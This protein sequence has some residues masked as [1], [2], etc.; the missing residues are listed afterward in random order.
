VT[1][2]ACRSCGQS[3][4]AAILSLGRTPLANALPTAEELELPEATYPLDLAFCTGC[5]LVQI[6]ETVPPEKLFRNYL[7]F[8]SF[9]DTLL[10][11]ARAIA[12]RLIESR[13]LDGKSL[14]VEAASNDGYLLQYY[15]HQGV[16]VL[17]IEPALNVARVAETERGIPTLREFF[18]QELARKLREEGQVA[19]VFHANN[20]LA[21]VAD[22]NGFLKGVRIVLK[23][24][25]LAV[26]EVPYVKEMIDRSEFDTIYHEHLCYF[27]LTALDRLFRRHGLIIR[28]VERLS[29]HGGSLRL[30]ATPEAT[31]C[32]SPAVC[33]LLA[34]ESAWGVDRVEA[35]RSFA[36]RV[37]KLKTALQELLG[38]LVRKGKRL[39]AYGAAAKGSTLLNYC[40]IG[41][42]TL[43]FVVDRSTYKQGRYMPGVHLPIFPP[44]RLLEAMPDYVLLLTW[45]FAEEI[46]AQQAEYRRRGGRF[47]IPIPEPRVVEL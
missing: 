9:S 36:R 42:E 12:E 29:I 47:I 6:L 41:R 45:N 37:E 19:D 23:K 28:D 7:Y 8:S 2:S 16:R 20:V 22:L 35:Y 27:S 21:H 1:N 5:A 40:G 15:R 44:G 38:D 17:G 24:D 34:E 26:I 11:H 33:S 3:S 25:G 30:F 13:R 39:A 14:V 32:P 4:L 10:Q 46:L 31:A 43:E 18:G